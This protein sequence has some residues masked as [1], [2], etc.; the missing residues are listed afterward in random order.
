MKVA[1]QIAGALPVA[2]RHF[3]VPAFVA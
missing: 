2:L 3:V 1:S